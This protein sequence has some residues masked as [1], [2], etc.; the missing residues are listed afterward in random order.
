M[1]GSNKGEVVMRWWDEDCIED[2]DSVI[3]DP[4]LVERS[5]PVTDEEARRFEEICQASTP[6]TLVIDDKSEGGGAVIACLPNGSNVVSQGEE[7]ISQAD[8][9]DAA[10]ANAEMICRARCMVLRLLRDRDQAKCREQGLRQ[11]IEFLENEIERR[12]QIVGSARWEE[13]DHAP[14]RPR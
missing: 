7:P 1:L 8:A 12:Q 6:G 3:T 9:V 4:L 14:M 11:R 13:A 2:G 10:R 5:Q